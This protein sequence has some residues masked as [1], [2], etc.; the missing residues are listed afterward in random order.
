MD[1]YRKTNS[2]QSLHESDKNSNKMQ[3][4]IQLQDNEY[5]NYISNWEQNS[6]HDI[7]ITIDKN[8]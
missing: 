2:N 1:H 4:I 3:N 6:Y 8:Q 7:S 5:I